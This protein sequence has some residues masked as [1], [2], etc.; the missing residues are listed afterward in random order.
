MNICVFCS[1]SNDLDKI[2]LSNARHLGTSIGAAGHKLVHGGGMIGLMG[3]LST[4]CK[5]AGGHVTGVVPERLNRTGIVNPEDNETVVTKD[6]RSRKFH[7]QSISDAFIALPGGF[8]TLEELLEVITLKQLKYHNKAIAI[9]NTNGFYD[10]L[11]AFFKRMFEESFA[12]PA[13]KGLFRVFEDL[14]EMLNYIENYKAE[15]IYDKYLKE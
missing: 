3:A 13:Y 12:L 9:L 7:M 8:G 10:P 14:S 11:L 5:E 15:H 6:M 1:S 4:S 2:Y